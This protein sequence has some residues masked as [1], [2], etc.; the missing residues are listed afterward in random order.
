MR[1]SSYANII[2]D[3]LSRTK[4]ITLNLC[5]AWDIDSSS[6]IDSSKHATTIHIT[7]NAII[8]Q[9]LGI[10][11]DI[12]ECVT[13]QPCHIGKCTVCCAIQQLSLCYTGTATIYVTIKLTTIYIKLYV[14]VCQTKLCIVFRCSRISFFWIVFICSST[15]SKDTIL[16][17]E[18]TTS[19]SQGWYSLTSLAIDIT[20]IDTWN[21]IWLIE[22]TW[23]HKSTTTCINSIDRMICRTKLTALD[24]N[25][26]VGQCRIHICKW[27]ICVIAMGLSQFFILYGS[28]IAKKNYLF[29]CTPISDMLIRSI[30]MSIITTTN[31]TVTTSSGTKDSTENLIIVSI[32]LRKNLESSAIDCHR[33][34]SIERILDRYTIGITTTSTTAIKLRD[35]HFRIVY[36]SIFISW[37]NKNIC[38]PHIGIVRESVVFWLPIF[39]IVEVEVLL[40]TEHTTC[41]TS[42]IPTS[43]LNIHIGIHRSLMGCSHDTNIIVCRNSCGIT[44][45]V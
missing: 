19:D 20:T 27:T 31:T 2:R 7:T 39:G 32:W 30:R 41:H 44:I 23:T 14:S 18:F 5:V 4:H 29:I 36:F 22:Q 28:R 25:I 15:R 24:D 38:S 12:D 13:S 17:I 8:R 10:T 43:Y 21:H 6:T 3:T 9:D 42:H 11:T 45:F 16:T 26:R 40:I 1:N 35:N 34:I 37:I 33:A